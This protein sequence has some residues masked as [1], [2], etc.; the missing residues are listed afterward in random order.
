M[1]QH[2]SIKNSKLKGFQKV[3]RSICKKANQG[4]W[5]ISGSLQFEELPYMDYKINPTDR[6]FVT[7]RVVNGEREIFELHY[8]IN[9]QKLLD[10]FL[11]K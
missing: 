5:A 1:A 10:I 9:T 3:Y 11:V 7:R 8:D 4:L 6:V 2:I